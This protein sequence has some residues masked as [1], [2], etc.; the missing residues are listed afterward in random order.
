VAVVATRGGGGGADEVQ[1]SMAHPPRAVAGDDAVVAVGSRL[2]LDGSG[3]TDADGDALTYRWRLEALP[4]TSQASLAGDTTP[5]PALTPDVAGDY[6]VALVVSDGARQSAADTLVVRA[7]SGTP[8]AHLAITPG[9]GGTVAAAAGSP[10]EGTASLDV[11]AGGVAETML[12]ALAAADPP[13]G[14]RFG[15]EPVGSVYDL[16]PEGT[17]FSAPAVLTLPV[18]PGEDPAG[19][20]IGVWDAAAGR[21]QPLETAIEGDFA[22]AR[23]A[24][25]SRYA[26]FHGGASTV[27]IVN[28]Q[29]EDA[30]DLPVTVTYVQGPVP[31]PGAEQPV[32][33]PQPAMTT[34][35]RRGESVTVDLVPG[36]YQ[37]VVGYPRPQ[38][39]VANSLWFAVPVLT[40]GADDGAVDQT[41]S[42]GDRGATSD[43]RVTNDSIVFPGR[44]AVTGSNL[45]PVLD[46]AAAVPAGVTVTAPTAAQAGA[47][48]SPVTAALSPQDAAGVRAWEIGPVKTAQLAAEGITFAASAADP[49][50]DT[51]RFVWTWRS[52]DGTSR[53]PATA[54]S[55][56]RLERTWAD[57]AGAAA[58]TGR[59]H[60]YL[61]AYDD[62]GLFSE[63]RWSVAV[64]GNAAP[65]VDVVVDD[66]VIDFGRLDA[67]RASALTAPANPPVDLCSYAGGATPLKGLPTLPSSLHENP[68]QYPAGMTCVSVIVADADLDLSSLRSDPLRGGLVLPEPLFGRGTLYS[69]TGDLLDTREGLAA[70]NAQL[71]ASAD[72]GLLPNQPHTVRGAAVAPVE[73]VPAGA[74]PREV[75][76]VVSFTQGGAGGAPPLAAGQTVTSTSNPN[77]A[78]P[79]GQ[80]IEVLVRHGS[81]AEGTATGYAVLMNVAEGFADPR[82]TRTIAPLAVGG[83]QVAVISGIGQTLPYLWEAPDDP[84]AA[85]SLHDRRHEDPWTIPRGGTVQLEARVADGWSVEQRVFGLV[86]FPT[87]WARIS[88]LKTVLEGEGG[89][90]PGA[91]RIEVEEATEVTYCFVITNESDSGI[92]LAALTVTDGVVGVSGVGGL[93][94][95]TGDPTA[96]LAPGD[97]MVLT[98]TM[99]PD[100]EA[101]DE[102]VNTVEVSA[103]P[104]TPGGTPLPDLL[105][106]TAT[107]TATVVLTEEEVEETTEPT[108][109]TDGDDTSATGSTRPP[110]RYVSWYAPKI[111][112]APVFVTT[113]TEFD[114]DSASCSYPGGGLD[115]TVILEKVQLLPGSFA[116]ATDAVDAT[117]SQMSGFHRLQG[118]IY[119]GMPMGVYQGGRHNIETIGGCPN[120]AWPAP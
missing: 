53:S 2:A 34:E 56:A 109:G 106:P 54:P 29:Q 28:A 69:A 100:G 67:V 22:S 118:E 6:R 66:R 41:I 92:S 50:G 116:S 80:V 104:V 36:R 93:G 42:V 61:T 103:D 78:V 52:A 85:G 8:L 114:G 59:T 10:E 49:E 111:G 18:P 65:F 27:R 40:G 35:L 101:G 58:R 87:P 108:S 19:L 99:V 39:G 46:C 24:H 81:W 21:W 86:A 83:T 71:L 113:Q 90:C 73:P 13:D 105:R 64:T 32:R 4:E 72:A 33:G 5:A 15:Q 23:L 7:V 57:T 112:W 55:P 117:C 25:L 47:A 17:A 89:T 75:P 102:I 70:Y 97:W 26:L 14:L 88:V 16:S 48:A 98:V 12:V 68:T 20:R 77:G 95:V 60:V 37:F 94:V 63:C 45:R 74:T 120:A 84:D 44:T 62:L 79:T 110:D 91:K 3:S 82:V 1:L 107:D 31:E 51:L 115:C 96:V 11:P 76:Y 30:S 119:F 43:N 38:P 9:T